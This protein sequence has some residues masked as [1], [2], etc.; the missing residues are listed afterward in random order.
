MHADRLLKIN[1][2]YFVYL[3]VGGRVNLAALTDATK[4]LKR[5]SEG[6]T[7]GEV[8]TMFPITR[9]AFERSGS[10]EKENLFYVALSSFVDAYGTWIDQLNEVVPKIE[11]KRPA[12]TVT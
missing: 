3:K 8:V 6:M 11:E 10:G 12:C 5:I 4:G 9:G 7:Y 2:F 1:V